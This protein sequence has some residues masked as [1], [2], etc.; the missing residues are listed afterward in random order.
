MSAVK[1]DK[2]AVGEADYTSEAAR[3]STLFKTEEGE[4]GLAYLSIAYLFGGGEDGVLCTDDTHLTVMLGEICVDGEL[5]LLI[6]DKL[7]AAEV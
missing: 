4:G 3:A 6:G 2:G 7:C 5:I 1:D